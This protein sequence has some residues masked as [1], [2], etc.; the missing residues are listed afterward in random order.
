MQIDRLIDNTMDNLKTV[1]DSNNIVGKPIIN[2]NLIVLPISKVSFGFIAGGGEY[3]A[4]YD[5]DETELPYANASGAGVNILPMGFLV[6]QNDE[7]KFINTSEKS[8]SD[9]KWAE[10]LDAG[11]KIIKDARKWY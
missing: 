3:G 4:I 5:D 2:G 9:N 8:E 7:I 1:I 10:L 6:S 11:M